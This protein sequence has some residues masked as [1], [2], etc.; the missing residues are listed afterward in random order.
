MLSKNELIEVRD[1]VEDDNVF[2][3]ATWLRGLRYGNSWFLLIDA[4]I[5]F[6]EYQKAIKV[7]L[8]SAD[9]IIKVACLKEEPSVI[10]G[11][12]VYS[13][14]RLHFTFVKKAWRKIGI[15]KSLVPQDIKVVSHITDT[16]RSILRKYPD[17]TFNP[18]NLY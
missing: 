4:K 11:Y 16:G 3:L 18:F 5:Y 2:I 13:N 10:L 14:G 7:L 17:V 6:A 1:G 9:T 12:S 8:A 15:A